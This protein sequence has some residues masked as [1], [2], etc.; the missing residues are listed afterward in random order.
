MYNGDMVATVPEPWYMQTAQVI[1]YLTPVIVFLLTGG[2]AIWRFNIFRTAKPSIRIDLE[3]SS[4][5]SS[6]SW[7]VL[8]AV[9]LVTNTSRVRASCES[10]QWEVRVLAPYSDEE[11]E[12]KSADYAG[13]MVAEGPPADF[14]WNVRRRTQNDNPGIDLEPGE[15]NVVD[16]NLPIPSWIRAVDVRCT[17]VLP[18][19]RNGTLYV[20]TS[21][22]SHEIS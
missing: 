21:I 13:Q 14:P 1:F 6:D 2:V 19:G 8:N 9:G 17:L 12:N 7:N 15:S 20:W 5:K 11:I 22:C 3:V 18:K 10:L 4:H 16:M